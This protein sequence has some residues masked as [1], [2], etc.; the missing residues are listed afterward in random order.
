MEFIN[1]GS[2]LRIEVSNELDIHPK[3]KEEYERRGYDRLVASPDIIEYKGLKPNR[4]LSTVKY[5]PGY[6]SDTLAFAPLREYYYKAFC[7]IR[8]S[9][10]YGKDEIKEMSPNL[11][12]IGLFLFNESDEDYLIGRVYD[13]DGQKLF[14]VF[15]DCKEVPGA[16][17]LPKNPAFLQRLV[18]NLFKD[19]SVCDMLEKVNIKLSGPSFMLND[20]LD[21]KSFVCFTGYIDDID[22]LCSYYDTYGCDI[23]ID[24]MERFKQARGIAIIKVGDDVEI[25]GDEWHVR[26]VTVY[27]TPK[28]KEIKEESVALKHK[29]KIVF[30][31]YIGYI[32]A[33]AILNQEAF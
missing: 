30:A 24:E 4:L 32:A 8:D 11:C 6:E 31:N 33:R 23:L 14:K 25:R 12:H 21:G 1:L 27:P 9:G 16:Y 17:L 29:D 7:D 22:E 15:Y 10:M 20:K 2:R 26:A 28:G 3:V 5:K 18:A 19:I 13:E